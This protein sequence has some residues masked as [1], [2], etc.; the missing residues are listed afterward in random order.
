MSVQVSY[1]SSVSVGQGFYVQF[2]VYNSGPTAVS[3]AS[4]DVDGM[5]ITFTIVNATICNPGC[6]QVTWSGGVINIGSLTTGSNV[7]Q[8][9]LKAPMSPT[10]FSGVVTLYYQGEAQPVTTTVAIRVTG[11]P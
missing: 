5:S 7:I 10:Q 6:S 2:S 8:V 3:G 4:L 9:G 1:P 11:R